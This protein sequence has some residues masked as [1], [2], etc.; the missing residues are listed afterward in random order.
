MVPLWLALHLRVQDKCKIIAPD[1]MN[2]ESL[3]TVLQREKE[4]LGHFEVLPFHYV[5]IAEQLLTVCDGDTHRLSWWWWQ[6]SSPTQCTHRSASDF[7]DCLRLRTLLKDI[8]DQRGLKVHD[9][10]RNMD[11]ETTAVKLNNLSAMEVNSVRDF[12]ATGLDLFARLKDAEPQADGATQA[13]QSSQAPAR[14]LR[15]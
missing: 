2:V 15:G 5:E 1:W 14:N 10:L 8:A 9:G 12:L 3:K 6:S 11:A 4:D 7:A 13:S